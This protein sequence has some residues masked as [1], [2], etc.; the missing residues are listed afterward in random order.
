MENS[1]FDVTNRLKNLKKILQTC[2]KNATVVIIVVICYNGVIIVVI[3][4]VCSML[5]LLRLLPNLTS[6]IE[7]LSS[8]ALH[9][10]SNY[11]FRFSWNFI[12]K[13]L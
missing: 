10:I 11:P 12:R 4:Y 13:S 7:E 2:L 5:R 3:I 6:S 9:F 1:I 8:F